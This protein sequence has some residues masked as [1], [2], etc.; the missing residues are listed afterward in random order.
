MLEA[1]THVGLDVHKQSI[2]VAVL[3]PRSEKPVQ[4][5]MRNEPAEVRR[6]VRRL[7]RDAGDGGTV[8]CAYEAGPCGYVLQRQLVGEGVACQVVA[9]SLIPRK[10][11]E[12]IKTD[13]R[14]A[15]KLAELL[16]A[17]L[18]TEVRPPTEAEEALRDLSRCR[19]DAR[20]DLMRARHRLGKMLLRRDLRYVE[21]RPWTEKHRAWLW[22]LKFEH[23]A[24]RMAFEDYLLAVDHVTMR[25]A[26]LEAQLVELAGQEP[27]R[28]RVGWLRCFRGIDTITAISLVAELH[29]F[30][31]FEK[32]RD[33][34]S[35]LGL[36]PRENSSGG[37]VRRGGITKTGNRHL[38]RLLTEVAHHCRHRPGVGAALRQRR[39][40]QPAAV[41][42]LAD[43]AQQRLHRRY[44]RL[45]L[46]RGLPV[47]KVVV[48]CAREFTG[49]L[50]ALLYLYPA[51]QLL[52]AGG[53]TAP[54]KQRL[55]RPSPTSSTAG[56]LRAAAAKTR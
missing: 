6:L 54:G 28:E 41:I 24:E 14:D 44:S 55:R 3:L 20:I 25:L 39:A 49:F 56:G 53:E 4:W 43:R 48:A 5:E 17:G 29:G 21:G 37:S 22:S 7:R 35:F 31:R 34:M 27:Y 47:Q 2:S 26:G 13:R 11:G 36:V 15:R 45:L 40:G 52:V 1:T 33:L 16:R 19:E 18:L 10:P 12:R 23:A 46:G 38:R 32:P 30:E 8:L 51:H 50:W 42:A 9:A